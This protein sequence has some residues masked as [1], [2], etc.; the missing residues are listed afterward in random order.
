M[1]TQLTA[2]D[3]K[4]SLGSHAASRAQDIRAKYGPEIGWNELQ[5][6]LQDRTAARYPCQIV[7][8]A[9]HLLEGEFAF[10]EPKSDRPED[11]FNIYIHPHFSNRLDLVPSLVL[12]QLVAV[13]YGPFAS[14]D[15]AEAF[16]AGVLGISRDDYYA[17]LCQ[18]ADE[19]TPVNGGCESPCV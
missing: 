12:Y 11:G 3:F 8:D 7:F 10:P 15:D 17:Q 6:I 16:G 9:G 14:P 13:N 2:D 19:I 5:L 1:P 4:Q 18:C